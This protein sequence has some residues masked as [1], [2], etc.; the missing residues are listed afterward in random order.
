[1]IDRQEYVEYITDAEWKF[2]ALHAVIKQ[3]TF[4]MVLPLLHVP[5][6]NRV[7]YIFIYHLPVVT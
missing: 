6:K 2:S 7:N 5:I 4:A 1:M 3:G